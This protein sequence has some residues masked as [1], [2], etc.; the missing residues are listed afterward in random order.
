MA[1]ISSQAESKTKIQPYARSRSPPNTRHLRSDQYSRFSHYDCVFLGTSFH[2]SSPYFFMASDVSLHQEYMLTALQS[3]GK[4]V[5]Y[6]S[7]LHPHH[8]ILQNIPSPAQHTLSTE[9]RERRM[10]SHMLTRTSLLRC[11][12]SLYFANHF[13]QNFTY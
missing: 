2:L 3:V 5:I 6:L 4:Q 11:V 10:G 12:Q 8:C 1:S 9:W 7:S 13:I